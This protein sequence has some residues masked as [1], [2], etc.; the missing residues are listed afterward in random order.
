MRRVLTISAAVGIMVPALVALLWS[1]ESV[2]G[3]QPYLRLFQDLYVK[4]NNSELGKATCNICHLPDKKDKSKDFNYF[5]LDLKSQM[6]K[7]K[8]TALTKEILQACVKLRSDN[9]KT[10]EANIKAKKLPAT[11]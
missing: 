9:G 10:Y 3:R 1:P 7:D 6:K 4:D 11:K 2:E 8:K 5:G